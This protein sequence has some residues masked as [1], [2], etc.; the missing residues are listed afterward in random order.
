MKTVYGRRGGWG[1]GDVEMY[2][3]TA[4]DKVVAA[5]LQIIG[6]QEVPPAQTQVTSS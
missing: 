6:Q 2:I 3:R 5:L 1:M 4:L